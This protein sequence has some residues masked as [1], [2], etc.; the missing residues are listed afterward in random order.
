MANY[1]EYYDYV[2]GMGVIVPDTNAIK[3]NVETEW[4]DVF[5]NNL[6]T[7]P[8]TPQGRIIEMET[9]TRKFVL[10]TA[11][12]VSNMLNLEKAYGFILDDIGGLFQLSRKSATYTQVAI[13]MSG[14][15]DTVIPIG[16]RLRSDYGDIFIN[17]YEYV[18]GSTGSV[19]GTFHAEESGEIPADVGSITTILDSVTGLESVINNTNGDIGELQES[20]NSFRNRIKGSL[21]INATSILEAIKSAVADIPEVKQVNA[22][23]NTTTTGVVLNTY[24]N[25]PA[26]GIGVVVDYQEA[27][28]SAQPIGHEIVEAIYKKKTLGA[29]YVGAETGQETPAADYLVTLAYTD[30]NDGQE[31]TVT[32]IKAIDLSVNVNITVQRRNYA[33]EDLTGDIKTAIANFVNGDNPEVDRVGIGGTLSPF[34]IGAAVSSE[35][36][37]IFI[38]EVKIKKT[39]ASGQASINP[40]VLAEAEKLVIN[41]ANITVTIQ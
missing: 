19:T 37:D 22:Y 8:E 5:G 16:T 40:I 11:A 28:A 4:K 26:H 14:V 21:N 9:R 29:G 15:V 36:P 2:T 1:A 39:S 13:T 41:P 3:A 17:D 31:H 10:E 33:G 38:S 24:F 27:D 23:E 20:D 34:E 32:F 18:I 30:P 12:A 6:N 35:I 7:D 25:I